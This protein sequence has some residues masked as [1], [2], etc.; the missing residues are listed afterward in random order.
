M[1]KEDDYREVLADAK[2]QKVSYIWSGH[3]RNEDLRECL[4]FAERTGIIELE[5]V[6]FEQESGYRIKW[7]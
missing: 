7:L 6:E 1:T 5:P 4:K 2:K 3:L